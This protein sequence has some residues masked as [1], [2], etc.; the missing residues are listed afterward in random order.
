MYTH[1]HTYTQPNMEK[2]SE[3]PLH[4]LHLYAQHTTSKSVTDSLDSFWRAI[5][6]ISRHQVI[7]KKMPM[8]YR[9][10]RM[11]YRENELATF[12][13]DQIP[14]NLKGSKQSA[15]LDLL[16]RPGR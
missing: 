10:E 4:A 5:K 8:L 13:S 11:L 15:E 1:T 16:R 12:G 3:D 2:H 7:Q 9:R 6:E 14:D